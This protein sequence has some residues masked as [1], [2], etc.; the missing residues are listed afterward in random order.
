MSEQYSA[1]SLW[2]PEKVRSFRHHFQKRV[3][4]PS[5][6]CLNRGRGRNR[7]LFW[8][9]PD[10]HGPL[11]LHCR[12]FPAPYQCGCIPGFSYPNPIPRPFDTETD[13]DPDPDL[14]LPWNFSDSTKPGPQKRVIPKSSPR[15]NGSEY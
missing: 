15:K 9:A 5:D 4:D 14:A 13:S 10:P 3:A 1:T 12:V 11:K 8:L 2:P 6:H 7:F